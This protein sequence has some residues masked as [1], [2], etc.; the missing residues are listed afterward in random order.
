[1]T[2]ALT[3]RQDGELRADGA[4]VVSKVEKPNGTLETHKVGLLKI[5]GEKEPRII[6]YGDYAKLLTFY[7][8]QARLVKDRKHVMV[9]LSGGVL[10]NTADITSLELTENETFVEHKP[11]VPERLA[12]F[13]AE[14]VKFEHPDKPGVFCEALCHVGPG[15]DGITRT[16]K[17]HN[18]IKELREF[19]N[20]E[21]GRPALCQIY[22]YGIPQL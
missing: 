18:E 8:G 2:N 6:N 15:E 14:W 21:Y 1:M 19:R 17:G 3:T 22:K 13:P 12:N 4:L 16:Y 20:D 5:R 10:V 9:A 7:A 11:T